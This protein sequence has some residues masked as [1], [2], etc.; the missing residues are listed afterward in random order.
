MWKGYKKEFLF[1][2]GLCYEKEDGSLCDCFWGCV[3]F[4]WFNISGKV[5]GFGGCVLDS[6]IKGVN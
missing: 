3:I 6:C 1:K 2:I 5:F 4:L